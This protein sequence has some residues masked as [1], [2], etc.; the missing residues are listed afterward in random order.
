MLEVSVIQPPHVVMEVLTLLV[1]NVVPIAVAL[2]AG[3][4]NWTFSVTD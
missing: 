1:V 2:N 3:P 4:R